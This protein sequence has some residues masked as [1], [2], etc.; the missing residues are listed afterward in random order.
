MFK[1]K[2]KKEELPEPPKPTKVIRGSIAQEK[3]P[4]EEKEAIKELDKEAKLDKEFVFKAESF[5][6]M[7]SFERDAE[8]A[9]LGLAI[10][11]SI[12]E[13]KD[14]IIELRKSVEDER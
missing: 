2:K 12:K 14:E 4:E 9:N 6:Q 8:F 1:R 7:R 5:L 11:E 13:L 3:I 10:L